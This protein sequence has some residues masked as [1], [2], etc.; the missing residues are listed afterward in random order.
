MTTSVA[1][2]SYDN[3]LTSFSGKWSSTITALAKK[4][5]ANMQPLKALVEYLWKSST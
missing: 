1:M 4:A 3:Q 5:S 2:G